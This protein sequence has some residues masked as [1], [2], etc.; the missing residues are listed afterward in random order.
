M[1]E[2]STQLTRKFAMD[3]FYL[4]VDERASWFCEWCVTNTDMGE[5]CFCGD[6]IWYSQ[7]ARWAA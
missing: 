7:Q 2:L 4:W 6:P 3:C 1:R 5:W